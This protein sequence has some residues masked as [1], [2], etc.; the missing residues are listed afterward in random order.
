MADSLSEGHADALTDRE[1]KRPRSPDA[2]EL[3]EIR[4]VTMACERFAPQL[5]GGRLVEITLRDGSVL[6]LAPSGELILIVASDT[7]MLDVDIQVSEARIDETDDAADDIDAPLEAY[8]QE[9]E[10]EALAPLVPA[11]ETLEVWKPPTLPRRRMRNSDEFSTASRARSV[12]ASRARC[13]ACRGGLKANAGIKLHLAKGGPI[14]DVAG[15]KQT[16]LGMLQVE[17]VAEPISFIGSADL[18]ERRP[19]PAPQPAPR[20]K[21]TDLD[22]VELRARLAAREPEAPGVLVEPVP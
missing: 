18:K 4:R 13:P 20:I 10:A 14:R 5:R 15:R 12:S 7:G 9:M 17:L 3:A 21:A 6:R 1:R 11:D 8:R 2:T 19:K 16:A 22:P